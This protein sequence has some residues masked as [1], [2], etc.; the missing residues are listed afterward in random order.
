MLLLGAA[1][2]P[3]LSN[4]K[5]MADGAESPEASSGYQIEDQHHSSDLQN[6]K[7]DSTEPK[8]R[9]SSSF[10]LDAKH[11]GN[12]KCRWI[13]D[14]QTEEEALAAA[15]AAAEIRHKKQHEEQSKTKL[16]KQQQHQEEE[17]EE[18]VREEAQILSFLSTG[19]RI[20]NLLAAAAAT[21]PSGEGP[22]IPVHRELKKGGG[23]GGGEGREG[24]AQRQTHRSRCQVLFASQAS[25]TSN[26]SQ[27]KGREGK[28]R[29]RRAPEKV[30]VKK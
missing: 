29:E 23:G 18:E 25:S 4:G 3:E 22:C 21:A 11:A 13:C 6:Q 5:R 24:G 27:G 17:E 1:I 8:L 28:G 9:R 2:F 30:K 12:S 16:K 26:Q 19:V 14:T 10:S 15:A 7:P 20:S